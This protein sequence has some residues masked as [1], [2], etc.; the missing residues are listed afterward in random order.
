MTHKRIAVAIVI[1]LL[2]TSFLYLWGAF[3]YWDWNPGEWDDG[4]RIILVA[5]DF[6]MIAISIMAGGTIELESTK[7]DTK[8]PSPITSDPEYMI[9]NRSQR[10]K[11]ME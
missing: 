8:P 2:S 10:F 3:I 7:K 5:A 1:Y 6:L 9:D 4:A 11:D